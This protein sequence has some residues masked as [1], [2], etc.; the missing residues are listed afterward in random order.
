MFAPGVHQRYF[1]SGVM[2]TDSLTD[3]ATDESHTLP[4]SPSV[5]PS[6]MR[7]ITSSPRRVWEAHALP[8]ADDI[9]ITITCGKRKDDED[10]RLA[11]CLCMRDEGQAMG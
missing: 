5:R 6:G 4:V 3:G 10:A 11:F 2:S 1:D 8:A 7:R 9:S